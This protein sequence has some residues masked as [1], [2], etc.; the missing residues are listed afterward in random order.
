L[1]LYLIFSFSFYFLRADKKR[2][3]S[4]LRFVLQHDLEQTELRAVATAD[5]RAALAE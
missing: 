3:G 5:V 2:S 1:N 4:E